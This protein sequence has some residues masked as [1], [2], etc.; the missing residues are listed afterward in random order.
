MFSKTSCLEVVSMKES[1]QLDEYADVPLK[2]LTNSEPGAKR[3]KMV[4]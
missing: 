3:R 1:F 4:S 2:R